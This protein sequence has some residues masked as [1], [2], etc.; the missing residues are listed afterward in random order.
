M[1]WGSDSRYFIGPILEVRGS[2]SFPPSIYQLV[3]PC[4]QLFIE[5]MY[6]ATNAEEMDKHIYHMG[7]LDVYIVFEAC[8]K[9]SDL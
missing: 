9:C 1:L 6:S 4:S 8:L 7:D 3:W 5:D 2:L